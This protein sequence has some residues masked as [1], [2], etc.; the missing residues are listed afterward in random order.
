MT[1][2]RCRYH[3]IWPMTGHMV[4]QERDKDHPCR[5]AVGG[6]MTDDVWEKFTERFNITRL[7][8][9]YGM[10]ECYCCL[11]SPHDEVRQGSCGKPITGWDVKIVDDDDQE[12][13]TGKSGE[14]VC[15]QERDKPWLGTAGYYNMPEKTLKLFKNLWIHSGDLGYM[16]EEGYFYFV[17]RKKE[18]IRRRGENITPHDIESAIG[19][20]PA[21]FEVAVVGVPSEV[22]EEEVKATVVLREGQNLDPVDLMKWCEERLAYFMIPRFVEFLD[23]LPKTGSQKIQKFKL[24]SGGIK[25]SWDREAAGY[26]L[27]R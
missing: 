9:V 8:E 13:P 6:G 12:C 18:A 11:A 23:K 14:I 7:V 10:T 24:K 20:H 15:R 19:E 25:N 26:V 1:N 27:K 2:H 5:I 17:G 16:D 4:Q 21:V 22:G 3:S